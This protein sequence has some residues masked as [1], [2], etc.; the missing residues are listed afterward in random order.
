MATIYHNFPIHSSPELVFEAISTAKGLDSW[1]SKH[2][3]GDPT[4]GASYSL[5]FG[6]DYQWM[7]VVT[8]CTFPNVFELEFV[9][10]DLDWN[11]S[12][13]GFLIE[14]NGNY[15]QF[16]FYH[17]GWSTTNENFKISS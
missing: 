14:P 13:V 1:W 4:I 9:Q 6:P 11:G 5:D 2:C 17:T 16:K 7:A 10:S 15:T 3:S 12:K 8:K